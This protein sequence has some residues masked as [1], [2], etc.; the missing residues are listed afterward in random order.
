MRLWNY[1]SAAVAFVLIAAPAL[2]TQKAAKIAVVPGGPDAAI[3]VAAVGAGGE[4]RLGISAFDPVRQ[5]MLTGTFTGGWAD[6]SFDT[7]LVIDGFAIKRVKPGTY[8]IRDFSQQSF[9]AVCFHADTRQFTIRPGEVLVLGALNA[10]PHAA[11]LDRS[12]KLTGSY[13]SRGEAKHFF[14]GIAPPALAPAGDS[15]M[16]RARA[17]VSTRMTRTTATPQPAVLEPARFGTGRDLFG[18]SR[19]CGGYYKKDLGAP[20]A[21]PAR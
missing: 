17:F 14:D 11:D 20:P 3:L 12:V 6:I 4:Q 10:E 16:E 8:V 21:E 18:T 13:S 1:V 7:K 15:L 5:N 19:I 9:W 2:A